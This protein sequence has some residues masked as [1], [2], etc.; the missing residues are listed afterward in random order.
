MIHR[1]ISLKGVTRK[2]W[3]DHA[4]DSD[5]KAYA[6][7]FSDLCDKADAM[8]AEIERLRAA[9]VCPCSDF[10]HRCARCDSDVTP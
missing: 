3:G 8:Q 6:D 5:Y 10:G 1:M 9:L 4:V 7:C 2:E